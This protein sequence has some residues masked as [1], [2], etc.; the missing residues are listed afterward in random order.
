M[1]KK[2]TIKQNLLMQY[3]NLLSS[4][5]NEISKFVKVDKDGL[6]DLEDFSI[7]IE[8]QINLE[9]QRDF[10]DIHASR[11]NATIRR[12]FRRFPNAV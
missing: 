3:K 5:D 8:E 6:L 10:I 9:W 12:Y 4:L 7:K 1:N 11:L 2:L